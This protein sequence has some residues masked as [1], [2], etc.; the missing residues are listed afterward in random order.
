MTS[1]PQELET[2][3]INLSLAGFENEAR[4]LCLIAETVRK[5]LPFETLQMFT[6]RVENKMHGYQSTA[7]DF[8]VTGYTLEEA[9]TAARALYDDPLASTKV[10]ANNPAPTQ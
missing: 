8:Q 9:E 4:T 6:V 2:A 10:I 5:K 3:A 7:K 1:I